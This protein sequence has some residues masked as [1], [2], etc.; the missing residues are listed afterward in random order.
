MTDGVTSVRAIEY[1][2]IKGFELKRLNV[3]LKI[4]VTSPVRCSMFFRILPLFELVLGLVLTD[5]QHIGS[6]F[7]NFLTFTGKY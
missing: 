6:A 2:H 4:A 5:V 7:G 1:H 3:G